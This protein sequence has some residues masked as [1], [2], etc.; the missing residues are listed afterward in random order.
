MEKRRPGRDVVGSVGAFKFP[1]VDRWIVGYRAGARRAAPG[2]VTL[3]TYSNSFT[4]LS[5]C[6]TIALDQIAKGAGVIFNV[7]GGCGSGALEAAKEKGVWGVGVD[8]DQSFLGPH[9]LTSA[10]IKVDVAVT[11]ALRRLVRGTFTTGGNTTFTLGNGGVGLGRISPDV[12]RTLLR[13]LDSVRRQII[14]RKID[15]P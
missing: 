1:G 5:K 4:S 14:A 9:I 10:V 12:P 8:V 13:E 7:A 11:A 6:R 2:V 15:V 3:N